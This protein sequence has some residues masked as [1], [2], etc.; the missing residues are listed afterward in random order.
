[1][2]YL[3]VV[4]TGQS[5][6]AVVISSIER[7][8]FNSSSSIWE[9]MGRKCSHCGKIGHN[10]RTCTS[11]RGLGGV[12]LRLFGVQ[13]DLSSNTMSMPMKKSFSMECLAS[14]SSSCSSSSSSFCNTN[15]SDRASVGYASDGLID[16]PQD[17]RKGINFFYFFFSSKVFVFKVFPFFELSDYHSSGL[18][19]VSK[20]SKAFFVYMTKPISTY[21][22]IN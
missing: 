15:S 11:L 12:G 21:I 1:M 8:E 3:F 5:V 14:S 22:D 4:W 7:K 20:P 2:C 18:L 13:L 6:V 17:R 9:R 16:A 10:S 19:Y